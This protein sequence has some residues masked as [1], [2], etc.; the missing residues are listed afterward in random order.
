MQIIKGT[1]VNNNNVYYYYY[2]IR[3]VTLPSLNLLPSP[4]TYHPLTDPLYYPEEK[5]S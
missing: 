4:K 2:T 5:S 1:L 3:S